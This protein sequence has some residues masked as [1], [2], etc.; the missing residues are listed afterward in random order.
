MK[1]SGFTFLRDAPGLYYP[2]LESIK[3]ILPLVDEYVIALGKGQA[4]DTT[5]A[6]LLS[7][8]NDKIKI[9]HTQWDLATYHGGSIYAQQTDWAKNHCTG[10]WLFYLQADE[11][12]H[13]D[14]LLEIKKACTYYLND[15]KVEGFVFNY[16]HFFGSYTHYFSDHCWYRNEIR[17]IRNLKGIHSW[18]DAQSFRV[19]PDFSGNDYFRTNNTRKLKCVKLEARVFHY[20]WVKPPDKMKTKNEVVM[21]N[22]QRAFWHLAQEDFDYGRLDYCKVF[23]KTH[24]KVMEKRIAAMD[25]GKKLR[26]SGPT[27]LGRSKMKHERLKYRIINFIEEKLPF[28]IR[29]GGFNNFDILEKYR[30]R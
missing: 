25:W 2:V 27:T 15:E 17:I 6:M 3:S 10:D 4:N 8:K 20:G 26:F 7:L 1:I 22:Y 23:K 21:K 9:I 18:K 5:E 29:L 13:E 28:S 16:L 14:D 30:N 11:V 19:I 24:P 12:I